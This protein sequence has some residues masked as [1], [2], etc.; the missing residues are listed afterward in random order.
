MAPTHLLDTRPGRVRLLGAW[1]ALTLAMFGPQA[2]LA[3]DSPDSAAEVPGEVLVK[4][5]RGDALPGVL[6]RHA[7][8]LVSRFGARPIFRL[9]VVGTA[10]V[11]DALASLALDPD[12]QLAEAHVIHRDPEAR[13]NVA[14]AIGTAQA[15]AV[16]WAPQALQ[17]SQAHRWGTGAGVRVAVLDTGVDA[18]HP[19]LAGR[20]DPGYDFVDGDLSPAEAAAGLGAS[21]GHGTHVAGLVALVAPGARIM[22]LRVLDADGS[23]NTWVLGEALLKATDPD[24]NPATDDGAHVVNLSLGSLTR[25]R[26]MATLAQLVA[27]TPPGEDPAAADLSDPGY[28]ADHARCAAGRS[29][30]IVAAAGNGG[31]RDEKQYPA[32]E[33]AYG[34]VSVAAS[35]V[36]G[37]L[38]GFSNYGNWIQLAAPGDALTS[39]VPGGL[40]GTWSGTSMAAPLVAATAALLRGAEPS[41]APVDVV[42]R[43]TRTASPMCGTPIGQVDPLAALRNQRPA[44]GKCR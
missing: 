30:V 11:A 31:S 37:R 44:G 21:Y 10:R 43:L 29:A 23:G 6:Q 15:Y 42:R 13:K 12:V 36:S 34:L 3:K 26:L 25:T 5:A 38:A 35:Q 32:A 33:G 22:P 18:A 7:L 14:W 1:L 2:G 20:V 8:T 24:G 9:R 39:S 27:C 40:Y 17:L 41:L 19:A 28:A 16:Q 4:L